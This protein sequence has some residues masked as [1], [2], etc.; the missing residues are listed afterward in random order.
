IPLADNYSEIRTEETFPLEKTFY[1]FSKGNKLIEVIRINFDSNKIQKKQ[2]YSPGLLEDLQIK[3]ADKTLVEVYIIY[4]KSNKLHLGKYE[5]RDLS[6][7][8]KEFPAVD[9][10]VINAGLLLEKEPSIYYWKEV[11]DTLTFTKAEIKTGP[12]EYSEYFSLPSASGMKIITVT[13]ESEPAVPFIFSMLV[14]DKNN[15]AIKSGKP[16]PN[17]YFPANGGMELKPKNI[18]KLF[19]FVNESSDITELMIYIPA[20]KTLNK[21]E[22]SSEE[23]NF[24]LVPVLQVENIQDYVIDNFDSSNNHLIYSNIKEGC[25]SILE[26]KQ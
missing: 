6:I 19:L 9:L 13:G 18:H 8:F 5:H 15:T 14:S 26:L 22:F 1:C 10:N 17:I 21:F 24:K 4:H 3:R 7:T 2:L 11:S 23:K 12:N 25:L 20:E 16:D